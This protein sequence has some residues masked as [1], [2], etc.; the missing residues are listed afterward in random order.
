MVGYKVVVRVFVVSA[1]LVIVCALSTLAYSFPITFDLRVPE[2]EAIDEADA[3]DVTN[4]GLTVT[5]KAIGGA[6]NRTGSG[7]GINALG[8][9]DDSDQIDDGSGVTE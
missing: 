7:F 1:V 9:N 8:G 2:I 6:L 3:F 4:G 5:L